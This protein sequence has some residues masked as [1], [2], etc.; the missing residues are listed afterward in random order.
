MYP[1]AKDY[2]GRQWGAVI[3]KE[4]IIWSLQLFSRAMLPEFA[5]GNSWSSCT[6]PAL[7]LPH[8][9][10]CFLAPKAEIPGCFS[11]SSVLF[12]QKLSLS[13][14]C[15]VGSAASPGHRTQLSH[16]KPS[17]SRNGRK[18]QQELGW[19]MESCKMPELSLLPAHAV[20]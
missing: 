18:A 7:G 19:S 11:T 20:G 2:A 14:S 10:Q 1:V 4:V 3:P 6:Q 9:H 15:S 12:S 13:T 16:S 8:K 17:Y 5:V